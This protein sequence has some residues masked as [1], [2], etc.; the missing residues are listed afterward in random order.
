M[1]TKLLLLF[2]VIINCVSRY[3][4]SIEIYDKCQALSFLLFLI[5]GFVNDKTR[6][7]NIAWGGTIILCVY[8]LFDEFF[9]DPIHMTLTELVS[10]VLI[11]AITITLMFYEYK[12]CGNTYRK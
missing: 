12:K 2:G 3:G 9:G 6:T 11:V 1:A 10:G 5:A 8:N 4:F 7:T